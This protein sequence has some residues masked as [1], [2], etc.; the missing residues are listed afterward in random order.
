[1][2]ASALQVDDLVQAAQDLLLAG[3]GADPFDPPAPVDD[4][5]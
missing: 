5:G 4:D 1:V 3:A 2:A